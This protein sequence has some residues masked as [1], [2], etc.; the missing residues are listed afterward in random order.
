MHLVIN[1][2]ITAWGRLLLLLA[3]TLSTAATAVARPKPVSHHGRIYIPKMLPTF[4]PDAREGFQTVLRGRASW[5]GKYFQGMKTA[6]GERYDRFQYTCAHKKL[7][8]GTRLRVTNLHNGVTVVVR[9][10]DRGPFRKERILD[11]SEKAASHLGLVEAGSSSIIAVIVPETTPLGLT[12]TPNDLAALAA[13]DPK[14]G[15]PFTAYLLPLTTR[16]KQLVDAVAANELAGPL[17]KSADDATATAV[18][19]S[20]FVIQ[21]GLFADPALAQA[22][23]AQAQ[24]IDPA[25]TGRVEPLVVAGM[26][27][28]RVLIGQLDNWLAAETVRRHLQAGGIVGLI[29]QLPPSPKPDLVA[30]DATARAMLN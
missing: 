3:L 17:A 14:P 7:P 8:F 24:N 15:A 2:S 26:P 10:A 20:K 29:K 4:I 28:N 16:S 9:V 25:L 13:G 21:A 18:P 30:R 6:S 23:L 12:D 1:N 11:L 22:Q 19:G 27:T 5:Y